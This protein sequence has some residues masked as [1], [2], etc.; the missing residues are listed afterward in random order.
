MDDCFTC[1]VVSGDIVTPG[2]LLFDDELI[3]VN[4]RAD[5]IGPDGP[6]TAWAG[7]VVVAPRRHVLRWFELDADELS[8]LARTAATVDRVLTGFGATRCMVSSLGWVAGDH[9]HVHVVPTFAELPHGITNGWHNLGV[10][11]GN[12]SGATSHD[13]ADAV[14]AALAG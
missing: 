14:R 5:G 2:G 13:V 1:G 8:A 7:W 10:P 12:P 4:H 6:Q 3:T 9:L 11:P